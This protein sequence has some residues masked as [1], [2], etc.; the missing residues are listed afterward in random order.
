MGTRR[1]AAS[2]SAS[3]ATP[4][5]SRIAPGAPRSPARMQREILFRILLSFPTLIGEVAE[6]FAAIEIPEAELDKLRREILE[7]E[8]LRPGLDASALRQHLLLNGFAATVDALLSPSV[9][10]G[11]SGPELGVRAARATNGLM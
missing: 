10:F 8:A 9:D 7:V 11:L 2:G 6:E 4:G 3:Q 1:P 5:S